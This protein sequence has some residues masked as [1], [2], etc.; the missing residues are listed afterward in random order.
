M[1]I[2]KTT[3]LKTIGDWEA[4]LAA[5]AEHAG[6]M[7]EVEDLRTTL[8]Q[9]AVRARALK[10]QQES[11]KPTRQGLTQQLKGELVKGREVALRIR[12][13]A[14]ARI[15]PKNESISQFG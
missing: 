2:S 11:A 6:T 13:I 10:A 1:P 7:P 5:V 15:G 3:Y 14:K 4:L 8:E 12:G 9:H